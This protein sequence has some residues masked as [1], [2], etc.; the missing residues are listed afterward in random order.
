M[1]CNRNEYN[2]TKCTIKPGPKGEP[3]DTGPAGM[4]GMTRQVGPKGDMGERGLK[5]IWDLQVHK[6][7]LVRE[8]TWDRKVNQ[9]KKEIQ[10]ARIR[11]ESKVHLV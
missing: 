10:A 3:G 1:S 11:K 5:V 9:V 8:E 7:K 4:K 6:E 2:H